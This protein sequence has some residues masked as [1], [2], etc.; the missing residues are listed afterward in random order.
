MYRRRVQHVHFVGIGG[1]G[2]SGI[3][4]VLLNL[5]YRV[6][7]SDVKESELTR[8]LQGL[9]AEIRY[10]H[11]AENLAEPHV[12]VVSSAV[13]PTNAEVVV[14]RERGIPV[15]PR[16]EMLAELMRMKYGVAIAGSHGKTTTTSMVATVLS[17]GGLDPT[18]VIGGRLDSL[19][20]NA[21][22]GQ[23]EF[24]V[25]E[26][27]ESDGS[28]LKLA[29]T[30]AVVTNIDPE[31]LDHYTGGIEQLKRAF[32]EFVN[33]IPFYGVAVLCLD[34]ENVQALLPAVSKRFTTY[35]LA[36]QADLCARSIALEGFE[37]E[38]EVV[39]KGGALG[40]IRLAMPG[41]HNVSNALA[42]VA[43]GLELGISFDA[44]RVALSGFGGVDRRFSLRGEVGGVAVIDDYGHHPAEIRATLAA[45]RR[46]F[47]ARKLVVV[48]QPHRY[49]RTRDLR[50]DF[51][52]SFNDADHLVVTDVYAAGEEPIEGVTAADLFDGIKRHGH[53]SAAY[54]GSTGEIAPHLLGLVQAGDMVITQ[55]AGDVWT[56][57]RD[58]LAL[59]TE[60]SPA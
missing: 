43:V 29:P 51:V 50:D 2:M 33:K 35:G 27:D 4:E 37:T 18:V 57:G 1:I 48:F 25:A 32:L 40:R 49:T 24:L 58:L 44:I 12:V 56:V 21:K 41:E 34:H 46:G 17:G 60:R 10:G 20:S 42:A 14:A 38:F 7:G 52:R 19:G 22:L 16:A 6:S 26:A 28:F 36:T 5:G 55:G 15:I 8:R 53:K 31:H 45:A 23:G 13:R 47:P 3:A 30:I 39:F 54:I 11:R 9:G 59:L